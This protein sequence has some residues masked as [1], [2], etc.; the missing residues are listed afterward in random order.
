MDASLAGVWQ[1]PKSQP[2]TRWLYNRAFR[3]KGTYQGTP[4]EPPPKGGKKRDNKGRSK[5]EDALEE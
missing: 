2:F 3:N 5:E 4:I 1:E